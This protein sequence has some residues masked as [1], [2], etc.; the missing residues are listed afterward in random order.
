MTDVPVLS[1]RATAFGYAGRTVV[2]DV[3]LQVWPGDVVAVL[4]PN[5]SGKSTVVKG[6]SGSPSGMRARF[7]SSA[8]TRGPSATTPGWGT[9]PSGIPSQRRCGPP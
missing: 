1:L 2:R 6:L 7:G 3:D 8:S 9:C 4:G 5:G